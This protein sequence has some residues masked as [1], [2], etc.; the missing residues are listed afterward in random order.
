[1]DPP[2]THDSLLRT[3]PAVWWGV[4]SSTNAEHEAFPLVIRPRALSERVLLA[5]MVVGWIALGG[6]AATYMAARGDLAPAPASI[7]AALR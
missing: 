2:P 1:M 7:G 4:M 3:H 5:A 6:A